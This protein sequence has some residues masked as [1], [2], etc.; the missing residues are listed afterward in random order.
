MWAQYAKANMLSSGR[1]RDNKVTLVRVRTNV[2]EN[3]CT[4]L[5]MKIIIVDDYFLDS[6]KACT[7]SLPNVPCPRFCGHGVVRKYAFGVI[8][9]AAVRGILINAASFVFWFIWLT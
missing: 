2:E 1:W 9:Y 7:A 8:Y 4:A 3:H 6:H 5:N